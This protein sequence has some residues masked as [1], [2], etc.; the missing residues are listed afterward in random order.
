[1]AEGKIGEVEK[2]VRSWK[3]K[4]DQVLKDMLIRYDVGYTEEL[5]KSIRGKVYKMS[6]DR[7]G[8]DLGF[9]K[10]GRFRDM[11]VGR[12]RKKNL[13]LKIESTS[14]NRRIIAGKAPKGLKPAKWFSKPFYGRLNALQGAIGYSMMEQA[15]LSVKKPIEDDKKG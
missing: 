3:D 5:F 10:H 12:G 8:Y 4:T 9:M 7:I 14:S 2:Y 6:S 11:N 15:I 1:M 13:S